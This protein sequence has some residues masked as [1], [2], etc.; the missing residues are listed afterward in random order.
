MGSPTRESWPEAAHFR[1]PPFEMYRA[2]DV[3]EWSEILPEVEPPYRDLV[4]SMVKYDR[5]R[6]TASEAL[7]FLTSK[8]S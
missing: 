8:C 2:F 4:S 3:R 5:S 1:T 6:A 7:D